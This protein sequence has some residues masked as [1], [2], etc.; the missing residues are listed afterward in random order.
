MYLSKKVRKDIAG[1]INGI[2]TA[3]IMI[4]DGYDSKLW[5]RAIARDTVELSDKYGI[6]LPS[7]PYARRKLEKALL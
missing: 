1:I 3:R 7:L 4:A 5:E 2:E 6:E